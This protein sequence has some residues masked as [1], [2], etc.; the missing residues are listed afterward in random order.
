M[1]KLRMSG[2]M[3]PRRVNLRGMQWDNFVFIV[4]TYGSSGY[5]S[6]ISVV[7]TDCGVEVFCAV[8]LWGCCR[9]RKGCWLCVNYRTVPALILQ[10]RR[11][12][13]SDTQVALMS[14]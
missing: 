1:L 13:V 12:F 4:S 14:N 3:Y 8:G 11:R 9:Q 2:S 5:G 10:R 6:C 7:I